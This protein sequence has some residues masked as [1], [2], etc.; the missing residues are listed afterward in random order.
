MRRLVILM[1]LAAMLLPLLAAPH[2]AQAQGSGGTVHVVQLG[3][4][5]YSIAR[6]YGVDATAIAT[7]NHLVNPNYIYAGQSLT[8]PGGSMPSYGHGGPPPP[9]GTYTVQLGD[10]L[11]S[12]AWRFGTTISALMAANNLPN[13]N[14]IFAGQ[15]LV[16][17]GGSGPPPVEK[18]AYEPPM[19]GYYPPR[20]SYDC[21]Y[22]YAV[23]PGDTLSG[24][25]AW[26]GTTVY[27]LA[28]ANGLRYPYTIYAGQR[29]HIPCDGG[30]PR[31]PKPGKQPTPAPSLH[32]AACA[33]EVQI[34]R[35][36]Q[37]ESVNGVVQI[38]GTARIGNFQFYK[39]EYAMGHS[40]LDSA[41][42]SID[43]V[44]RTPVG[45]SVL[46]TWYVGNMP[47]GMYT[48]RLTAV[49]TSGQFPRP[50]N[51]HINVVH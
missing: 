31:R 19:P 41:F 48:V 49:D 17:P 47:A 2:T 29:L 7:A 12:I 46:T 23:K 20:H 50:C 45:D 13:A 11:S 1:L 18:P 37:G 4:T 15:V 16:I 33:R 34:V 6:H 39:V 25:A 22:Y 14:Y 43:D 40:P 32:P 8:I 3:E 28:H 26:H 30:T 51:V 5:L 36:L 27:A 42:H 24:I 35:P 9:G 44:H 10:T 38:I 21:G